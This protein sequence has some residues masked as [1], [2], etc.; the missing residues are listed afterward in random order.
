MTD[1]M[2]SASEEEKH[3]LPRRP[4]GKPYR[5][6]LVDD[7]EFMINNLRR[8]V[9][10]FQAEVIDSA[11]D[12]AQ[13]ILKYNA[14]HEKPDLVTMDLTMPNMGG[15][16]AIQGILKSNPKQKIIVVSAMGHKEA[17]QEA[18]RGG[19]KHFVVKPFKRDD[20][21]RVLRSVLGI[22]G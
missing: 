5:F 4:D 17:I 9:A 15:F 3:S 22:K 2:G 7:S 14:M 13:A 11:S 10:G 1:L 18:I 19:A 8:I 21:Y 12:G 6:M 16:E 20:V